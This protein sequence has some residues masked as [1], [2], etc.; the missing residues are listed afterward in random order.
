MQA[1]QY[2]QALPLLQQAVQKLSGTGSTAEAY[3]L[4][5]LAF[6]EF[7]LGQCG[8]VSSL[9]DQSEQIQGRR[10]EIDRLRKQVRKSC[11]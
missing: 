8:D 4:Y 1:G 9:L 3:A 2:D 7:A 6:T 10:K 5:N 11:G